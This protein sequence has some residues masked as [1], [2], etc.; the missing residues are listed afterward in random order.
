MNFYTK[1]VI[2]IVFND[3]ICHTFKKRKEARSCAT[4]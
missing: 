4:S 1:I 3:E 2:Y